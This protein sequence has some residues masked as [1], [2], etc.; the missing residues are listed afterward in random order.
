[1]KLKEIT[2]VKRNHFSYKKSLKEQKMRKI[3]SDIRGCIFSCV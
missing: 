3:Y 1:M 2:L